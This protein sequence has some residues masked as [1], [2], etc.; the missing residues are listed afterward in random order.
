MKKHYM[1]AKPAFMAT[2]LLLMLFFHPGKAQNCPPSN[3]MPE[4]ENF[5]YTSAVSWNTSAWQ[6]FQYHKPNDN[7]AADYMRFRMMTPNGFNRCANDGL[8]Y[9]LIVFLHGSGE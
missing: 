5:T 4:F 8:K 7:V 3:T 2:L 9:P 6:S 1:V